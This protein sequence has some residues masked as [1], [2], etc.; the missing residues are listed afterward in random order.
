MSPQRA[1]WEYTMFF[2]DVDDWNKLRDKGP[3]RWLNYLTARPIPAGGALTI[4]FTLRVSRQQTWEHLLQPYK[5]YFLSAYG[6][7]RYKPDHRWVV[8]ANV[9]R[10]VADIGP[11]NPYGLHPDF[12]RLDLPDMAK[13]FGDIVLPALK[14]HHG[15]GVLIW[16]HTG[17]N[18]H[19]AMYRADFDVIPP[20]I[21]ENL[22]TLAK[23]FNDEKV[24][25]GVATRPGEMAIHGTWK[26]DW[27]VAVNPDDPQQLDIMWGRF[28]HMIDK[29][30]TIFYLDSFGN[31]LEHARIMR[32]L[33]EKMGPNIGTYVEQQCDVT[34]PFSGIYTETDF[35][36]KGS[37]DWVSESG[38]SP[39][40]GLDNLRIYRWLLGDVGVVT[41]LYDVHGK[42]PDG[43]EDATTFFYKNHMTPLIPDFMAP[44]SG[45]D[46]EK[47]QM[48]YVTDAGASKE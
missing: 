44:K 45:I 3:G 13:K 34:L 15:Q 17:E 31:S 1:A 38:Y 23:R 8:M 20:E 30:C 16:G 33:R 26:E 22:V 7:L 43:F 40:V 27:T 29:G 4:G 5:D 21:D 6:P 12:R 11:T 14:D 46:A 48:Q 41:R 47:V 2:W 39:R 19:G 36:A 25:F 32:Y 18:P 35:W 10:S 42:I 37:A 28:K 9:N 24:Q